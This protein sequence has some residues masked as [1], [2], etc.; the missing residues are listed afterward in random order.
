MS[1]YHFPLLM[2]K[3]ARVNLSVRHTTSI[4]FNVFLGKFYKYPTTTFQ[5][6]ITTVYDKCISPPLA[7]VVLQVG[8]LDNRKGANT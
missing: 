3:Y 7:G 2:A 4:F 1:T 8:L 6:R 5:R